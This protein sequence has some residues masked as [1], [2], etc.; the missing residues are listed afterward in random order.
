MNK[1]IASLL[2]FTFRSFGFKSLEGQFLVSFLI[3]MLCGAVL[4]TSQYFSMN[5][6]S[7]IIDVAGRQRMLSQRMAKEALLIRHDLGDVSGLNKTIKLFE[8]SHQLLLKGN[9]AK[10]LQAVNDPLNFKQL[11]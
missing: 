5:I 2:N 11:K 8:D 3:I 6:D 1:S 4:I 7:S 10:G 9:K